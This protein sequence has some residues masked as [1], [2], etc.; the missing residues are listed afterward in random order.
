M[1]QHPIAVL[2][3]LALHAPAVTEVALLIFNSIFISKYLVNILG[4]TYERMPL[5]LYSKGL[6]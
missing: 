6:S 2:L 4:I 5:S 3:A 1:W